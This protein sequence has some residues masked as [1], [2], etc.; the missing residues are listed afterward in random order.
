MQWIGSGQLPSHYSASLMISMTGVACLAAGLVVP[1]GRDGLL[2]AMVASLVI[3]E[4]IPNVRWPAAF[5]WFLGFSLTLAAFFLNRRSLR[6][7]YPYRPSSG[8]LPRT[9]R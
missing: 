7:S 6:S 1:F 9:H 2:L 5:W 4:T 3:S 8:A